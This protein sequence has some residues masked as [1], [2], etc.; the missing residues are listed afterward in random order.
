MFASGFLNVKLDDSESSTS[1]AHSPNTGA[2][3][4]QSHASPAGGRVGALEATAAATATFKPPPKVYITVM[5]ANGFLSDKQKVK[6]SST[7][8]GEDARDMT[9][10]LNVGNEC[11]DLAAAFQQIGYAARFKF[12]L[13][14]KDSLKDVIYAACM[15]R[16]T[17]PDAVSIL[18]ISCHADKENLHLECGTKNMNVELMTTAEL[19]RL[20]SKEYEHVS[21]N[22]NFN[23]KPDRPPFDLVLL[24][25]CL[26]VNHAKPFT[27]RNM[28]V[29]TSGNCAITDSV[30]TA[31]AK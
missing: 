22:E 27:D 6:E 1:S 8:D 28:P 25:C 26:G 30:A 13:A 24:M 19:N 29:I 16:V 20:I 14:S 10:L 15:R 31:F 21:E 9:E 17:E 11:A 12:L 23:E 2:Q 5:F 18:Q 3:H 7:S 4:A